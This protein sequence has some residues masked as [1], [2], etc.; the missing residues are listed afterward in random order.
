MHWLRGSFAI[1]ALAVA[2]CDW[3][4]AR[5]APTPG[6]ASAEAAPAAIPVADIEA[7][8]GRSYLDFVAAHQERF[9]AEALG[10]AAA[11]SGRLAHV[12]AGASGVLLEGGGADALVFRGCAETGC[13]DGV[14]VVAVDAATGASFVGV[15]DS[16]GTDVL[17]P[18][19][20]LEALLRLNA[21]SRDWIDAGTPQQPAN[22]AAARP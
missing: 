17:A 18:N 21:P 20:R 4:A 6:P 19:D 12:M 15:R 10:L 22:T 9:N 13:A 5:Q 16:G 8:G 7:F 14:G 1:L 3:L 11:D 2:G